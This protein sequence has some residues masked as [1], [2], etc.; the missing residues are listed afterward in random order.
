MTVLCSCFCV[1]IHVQL[2][3]YM[4]CHY[5]Y[6]YMFPCMV[7]DSDDSWSLGPGTR[8][9]INNFDLISH[10]SNACEIVNYS[11]RQDAHHDSRAIK[12]VTKGQNFSS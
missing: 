7:C 10:L 1:V 4:G 6:K 5:M 8:Q 3:L 12:A 2:L 9:K 11:A